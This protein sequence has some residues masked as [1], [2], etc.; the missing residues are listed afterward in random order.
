LSA[1]HIAAILKV[2][3]TWLFT[4]KKQFSEGAPKDFSDPEEWRK[5]VNSHRIEPIALAAHSENPQK[6]TQRKLSTR[7]ASDSTQLSE[8]SA[9]SRYTAARAQRTEALAEMAQ[10]ELAATKR[11]MVP[12]GQVERAFDMAGQMVKNHILRL[13]ADAPCALVGKSEA[14]VDAWMQEA[15]RRPLEVM[16]LDPNLFKPGKL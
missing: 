16:K 5:F 1:T 9:H 2:S 6:V 4:L 3:R 13:A 7:P 11:D 14:E 10:I 12:R 8:P 15:I